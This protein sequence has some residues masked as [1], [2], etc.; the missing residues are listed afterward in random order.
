M[1]FMHSTALAVLT[2][3]GLTAC[4]DST[5]PAGPTDVTVNFA[6]LVNGETLVCGASYAGVGVSS[7]EITPTDFRLYVSDVQLLRSDGSSEAL[8]LEQDGL[9]QRENVALL[10]FENG[11][12]SCVNGTTGT[13]TSVRGTVPAGS[14]TGLRF[15]LGVP[16]SLNHQDQAAAPP[17][18]DLSALFWSW[19]GGY[20]F[21]RMDHSSS[22]TS[23]L[24]RSN[25]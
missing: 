13:N 6:A 23:A 22:T 9:W 3:A 4:D 25:I 19:N 14:Y 21:V 24:S 15:T 5:G 1:K 17:P 11:S 10:D 12:A 18:F 7:T 2:L 20:K 16:A 8:E